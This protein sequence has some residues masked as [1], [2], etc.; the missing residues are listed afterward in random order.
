MSRAS[1]RRYLW[2][3]TIGLV[4]IGPRGDKARRLFARRFIRRQGRGS[5]RRRLRLDGV[6]RRD[7]DWIGVGLSSHISLLSKGY[8]R[9]GTSVPPLLS[10]IARLP[11]RFSLCRADRRPMRAWRNW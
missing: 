11:G 10:T 3:R 9:T 7:I 1:V 4:V 6:R 2:N 8:A 5:L